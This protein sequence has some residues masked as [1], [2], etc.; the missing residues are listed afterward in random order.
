MSEFTSTESK[1][2]ED[3]EILGFMIVMVFTKINRKKDKKQE[4]G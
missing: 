2:L 4:A 1:T 3:L